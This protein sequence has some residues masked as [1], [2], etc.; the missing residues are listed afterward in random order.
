MASAVFLAATYLLYDYFAVLRGDIGEMMTALF[1]VIG[2]VFFVH[3]LASAVLSP[4]LP[5]WRLIAV[6]T[7]AARPLLWLV[8]ATAFFTGIDFFLSTVYKVLDRR[9]R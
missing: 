5:N 3:R 9:C 7:R 6:D 2:I 8:S 4:R 1:I